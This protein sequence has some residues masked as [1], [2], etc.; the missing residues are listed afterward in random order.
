MLLI[1]IGQQLEYFKEYKEKLMLSK[2]ESIANEIIAQAL[3]IFSAGNTDV[4]VSYVLRRSHFTTEE[5]VTY[6]I[7]LADAA[8]RAVYELGARKILLTGI[9][10]VECVPAMRTLNLKQPGKCNEAFNQLAMRYNTELQE[11]AS[12][13]DGDLLGVLV[14]YADQLYSVVSNIIANPLDYDLTMLRKVVVA[15]GYR[16][17]IPL[18]LGSRILMSR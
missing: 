7:G 17:L 11:L 1:P 8:V 10:P 14:V 3:Y 18:C 12:K 4:G 2:G 13:L 6:L 15:L 9:L 16:V 5:Y